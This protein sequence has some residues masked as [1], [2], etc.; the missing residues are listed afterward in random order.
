MQGHPD[1]LVLVIGRV[2]NIA[3]R[4]KGGVFKQLLRGL[5]DGLHGL[6]T[7]I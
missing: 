1:T 5:R 2:L 7:Y 6:V 4:V 3:G